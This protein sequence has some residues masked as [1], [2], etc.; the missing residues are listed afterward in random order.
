MRLVDSIR[1]T[2]SSYASVKDFSLAGNC[3][4]LEKII[5]S[6]IR[7]RPA[8]LSGAAIQAQ[9]LEA[10]ALAAEIMAKGGEK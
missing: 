6:V 3:A 10:R 4:K 9:E 7:E 1:A 8:V 5:T 2:V